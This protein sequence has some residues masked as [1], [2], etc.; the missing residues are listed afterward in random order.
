[1]KKKEKFTFDDLEQDA[2]LYI[3]SKVKLLGSV[4]AVKLSYRLDDLVSRYAIAYAQGHF[5]PTGRPEIWPK[6]R[7]RLA[8]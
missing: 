3:E 5:G 4:E 1:M 6:Q 7:P 8:L 2:K